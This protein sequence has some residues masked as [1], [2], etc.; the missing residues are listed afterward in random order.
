MTTTVETLIDDVIEREGGFVDHP[1][2]RG[3]AT[4]F[5]VTRRTLSDWLGRAAS[6]DDVR[7]MSLEVARAI[8]R[9]EY[10]IRPGLADL[11]EP[12]HA[13]MLDA[14]VHHG[15]ATAIRM[16]QRLL[17]L[18]GMDPGPID[19]VVGP[20]TMRA[21]EMACAGRHRDLTVALIE[22]R[23]HFMKEIVETDRSQAVFFNG[24]MN[25][26]NKLLEVA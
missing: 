10:F 15:P 23:R 11:P 24:W 16:L 2:D 6:V 14:S 3:G 22:H 26:L 13:V 7:S 1:A 5:G 19:G 4:N 20:K 12:L 17:S 21:A 25:R 8:Y 18:W 9:S